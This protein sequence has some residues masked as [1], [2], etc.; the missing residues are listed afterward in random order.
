MLQHMIKAQI[1]DRVITGMDML[2]RVRKRRLNHKG[3][4]VASLRC[5]SMVGAGVAAFGLDVRD[6]AVLVFLSVKLC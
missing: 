4:R 1:L 5:R 6:I 3:G 2:I